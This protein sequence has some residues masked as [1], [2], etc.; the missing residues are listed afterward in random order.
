[1]GWQ[2]QSWSASDIGNGRAE[3]EDAIVLRDDV[4]LWSVID[5]NGHGQPELG[6]LASAALAHTLLHLSCP[7]SLSDSV[8]ALEDVLLAVNGQLLDYSHR[9]EQVAVSA[10]VGS[11]HSQ[12][13]WALFQW[14]GNVRLY[15]W[16]AGSLERLSDDHVDADGVISRCIGGAE[17]WPDVQLLAPQDHDRYLLCSDGLHRALSEKRLAYGMAL[18]PARAIRELMAAALAAGASDNLSAV[19]LQVTADD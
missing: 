12:G 4:R 16:R 9:H 3:N 13:E 7:E 17:P 6:K 11:F 2:W 15:R 14:L 19:L 1:M 8:D 5:G 10:T 18:E